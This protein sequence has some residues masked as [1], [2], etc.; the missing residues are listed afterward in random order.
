MLTKGRWLLGDDMG[1]ELPRL[2]LDRGAA[3]LGE[4]RGLFGGEPER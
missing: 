2:L 4:A 3:C 1:D